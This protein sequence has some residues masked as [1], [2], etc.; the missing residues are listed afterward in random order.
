MAG[1]SVATG[2][3]WLTLKRLKLND[4]YVDPAKEQAS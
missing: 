4:R 2:D 1:V 3:E